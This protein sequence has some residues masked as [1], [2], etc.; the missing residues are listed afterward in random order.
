MILWVCFVD[1]RAEPFVVGLMGLKVEVVCWFV[2]GG[3]FMVVIG[4]FIEVSQILVG[5]VGTIVMVIGV[6][7][8][9]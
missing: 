6:Y 7:L 4:V 3:G 9:F 2:D 5:C 8:L 1:L